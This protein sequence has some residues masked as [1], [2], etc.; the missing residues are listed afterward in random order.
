MGKEDN[1]KLAIYWDA[2]GKHEITV[3]QVKDWLNTLSGS[4]EC[5]A[6]FVYNR[7][8]SRYLKPFTFGDY[9]SCPTF[10]REYKNGFSMMANYC[11]FIEAFQSFKKGISDSNGKSGWLFESF[12]VEEYALFP[13]L[14]EKGFYKNVRCGILHQGETTGGWKL[15]RECKSLFDEDSKTID[16]VLF[17][18]Q[19]ERVLKN[20]RNELIGSDPNSALWFFCKKKILSII[21]NCK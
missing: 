18:K 8:Y 10:R 19:L 13:P 1:C 21:N 17:G 6:D 16:A 20:Y 4:R 14:H 15:S 3:K 7:L 11:L 9:K 5:L 2:K 12:F